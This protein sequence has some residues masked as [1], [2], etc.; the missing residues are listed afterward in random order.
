MTSSVWVVGCMP[1]FGFGL[2]MNTPL[3]FLGSLHGAA[4]CFKIILACSARVM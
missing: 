4:V 1:L 3:I 2:A